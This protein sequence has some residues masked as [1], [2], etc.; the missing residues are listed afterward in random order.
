MDA[1][2]DEVER[3]KN[4][5]VQ[6]GSHVLYAVA[7]GLVIAFG[8]RF[9]RQHLEVTR[10]AAAS[11]YDDTSGWYAQGKLGAV[12]A[13]VGK[14]ERRYASTPYAPLGALLLAKISYASG[15]M[16]EA[17][18]QLR[19]VVQHTS[20]PG[21]KAV[22]QL[23]L[24]RV[25]VDERRLGPALAL[26]SPKAPPGFRAQYEELRGDILKQQGHVAQ[27]RRA[28]QAAL[29]HVRHGTHYAAILQMK[30]DD[31]SSPRA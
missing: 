29:H 17:A 11:I 13:A 16:K 5:L 26:V 2:D 1:S 28:Y 15:D 27:A 7:F 10:L 23:R 24:G 8:I 12:K 18:A 9:W 3:V 6:N 31:L 25:L 21:V 30:L 22:A 14:L 19:W 4:W 20:Q